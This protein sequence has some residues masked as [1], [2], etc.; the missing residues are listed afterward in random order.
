[1]A[2]FRLV[3]VKRGQNEAEAIKCVGSPANGGVQ[4]KVALEAIRGAFR[5]PL[6]C[7]R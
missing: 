3:R 6:C 7:C 5:I 1:M 2:N 4:A